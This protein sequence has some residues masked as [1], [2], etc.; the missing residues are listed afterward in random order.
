MNN[1]LE[2]LLRRQKAA[3]GGRIHLRG[4]GMDMGNQASQDKSANMGG[5][6]GGLGNNQ[7]DNDKGGNKVDFNANRETTNAALERLANTGSSAVADDTT[8]KDT[9]DDQK[10]KR[11]FSD[12]SFKDLFKTP[13]PKEKLVNKIKYNPRLN[14]FIKDTYNIKSVEDLTDAQVQ[15]IN[16]YNNLS[17]NE[18]KDAL[19]NMTMSAITN[20][21]GATYNAATLGS[22][23]LTGLGITGMLN[24]GYNVLANKPAFSKDINNMDVYGNYIGPMSTNPV[25]NQEISDMYGG[26]TEAQMT[27][28]AAKAITSSETGG[29]YSFGGD[30]NAQDKNQAALQAQMDAQSAQAFMDSLTASEQYK[31]DQLIQAG[32]TDDYAKAYLGLA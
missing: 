15:A 23:G 32:Y 22:L 11:L 26:L 9:S 5:D 29:N 2:L 16:D 4:G 21:L 27:E 7:K 25:V 3:M 13:T 12:F 10:K 31:Y 6:Y 24:A 19:S 17:Y 1:P 14:R 8:S 20:P 18:I 30:G 28:A